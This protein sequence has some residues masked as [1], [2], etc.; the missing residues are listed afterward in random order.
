M[1][2]E[3]FQRY[4]IASGRD[5]L[6]IVQ[7]DALGTSEVPNKAS[8]EDVDATLMLTAQPEVACG[9]QADR[10]GLAIRVVVAREGREPRVMTRSPTN[11]EMAANSRQYAP[12]LEARSRQEV[13]A[14]YWSVVTALMEAQ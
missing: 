4:S 2:L 11:A 7:S 6:A 3:A 9:Y 1:V 10:V 8:R 13:G 12:A 14:A 5:L